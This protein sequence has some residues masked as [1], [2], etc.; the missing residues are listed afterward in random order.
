MSTSG[1]AS[2]GSPTSGGTTVADPLWGFVLMWGGF[3]VAGAGLGWIVIHL[4][5]WAADLRWVP[6]QRPLEVIADFP[7]AQALIVAMIVGAI[8]GLVLA[9][10]GHQES[11]NVQV[12]DDRVRFSRG[13]RTKEIDRADVTGVFRDGKDL[14][15]IGRSGE[16]LARETSDLDTARLRD[17][18]RAHG[19]AWHADGDP[20]R[21]RFRRW[22]D[23]D[24]DL[25]VRA[26]ALLRARD[27]ALEKNNKADLEEFRAA[28][29][30]A[31]VVVRDEDK[32]QYWRHTRT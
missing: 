16:E 31:G 11:L 13:G 9:F 29:S 18:F 6:F 28:L 5:D 12:G 7:R 20:H 23:G 10:I 1:A 14:V 17:A 24:P 4:A 2:S 27:R 15:M 25:A 30:E 21:D 32:K 26:N 19:Y 8:A 3:P 22:I